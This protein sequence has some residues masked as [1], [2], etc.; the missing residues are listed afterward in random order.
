MKANAIEMNE[1]VELL[2]QL[3]TYD[4]ICGSTYP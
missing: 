3:A 2:A 1:C 4:A